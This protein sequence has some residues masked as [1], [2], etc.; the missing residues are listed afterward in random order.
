MSTDGATKF[1]ITKLT[2]PDALFCHYPGE[3]EIQSCH[4]ALDLEDGELT[5]GYDG[6]IGGGSPESVYHRRALWI[7]IP[8]LTADAANRLMDEAAP[9][10]QR[11]LDGAEI[12]WD[13]NNHVGRLDEDAT[14]ALD[15]LAAMCD[16]TCFSGTD[17]VAEYDAGGWF[18]AEGREQV[19][20]RLGITAAT[21]DDQIA[22]IAKAEEE[23]ARTNT[24]GYGYVLLTKAEEYLTEIRD[25][26][27]ADE[28]V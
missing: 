3:H 26:L 24:S 12:V 16:P 23:D 14:D 5:A 6:N 22:A 17:T 4:L 13:G 21:T 19:I 27:R 8:T 11:I 15:E 7:G 18:G 10:A 28:E 25:E 20:E 2:E 9:L 1:H